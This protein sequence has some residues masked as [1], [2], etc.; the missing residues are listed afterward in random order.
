M[1]IPLF[2]DLSGSE[3]EQVA[4]LV[5]FRYYARKSVIFAQGDEREAVYIIRDVLVKTFK[6]DESGHELIVSFL[7]PGDV[8]PHTG[9]FTS[10]PYPATSAAINDVP[11][12]AIPIRQIAQLHLKL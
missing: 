8:F 1:R 3:M 4:Q 6:T 9:L 7:K 11:L 2:R 5:I 10:Q 12:A